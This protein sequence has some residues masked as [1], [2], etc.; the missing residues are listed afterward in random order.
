MEK[1]ILVYSFGYHSVVV[2]NYSP[3]TTKTLSL[4]SSNKIFLLRKNKTF[5]RGESFTTFIKTVSL[6]NIGKTKWY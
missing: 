5:K 4:N 3:V 6:F 1:D 2:S